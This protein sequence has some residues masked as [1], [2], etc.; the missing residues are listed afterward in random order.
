MTTLNI[1]TRYI[2]S[3]GWMP[4][5]SGASQCKGLPWWTIMIKRAICTKIER[6]PGAHWWWEI[7]NELVAVDVIERRH[8]EAGG[9][10]FRLVSFFL[11][12]NRLVSSCRMEDGSTRYL[13][14]LDSVSTW[15]VCFRSISIDRSLSLSLLPFHL[16]RSIITKWPGSCMP[17]S[18]FVTQTLLL[19]R[20]VVSG[21]E[22]VSTRKRWGSRPIWR[23]FF[24]QTNLLHAFNSGVESERWGNVPTKLI[25]GVHA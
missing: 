6:R 12:W 14:R 11:L 22:S 20:H 1:M 13:H 21:S 4:L 7:E 23:F 5:S 3:L 16:D 24:W 18:S 2:V 17:L 10:R 25:R 19:W 15:P 8:E 9:I